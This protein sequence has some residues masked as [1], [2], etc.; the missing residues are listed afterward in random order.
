MGEETIKETFASI[1]DKPAYRVLESPSPIF[2]LSDAQNNWRI[3]E[4]M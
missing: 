1:I 4:W 2:P 3:S